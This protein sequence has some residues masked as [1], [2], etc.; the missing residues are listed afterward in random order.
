[1]SERMKLRPVTYRGICDL[2]PLFFKARKDRSLESATGKP[3]IVLMP[4]AK[5]A[6]QSFSSRRCPISS[7]IREIHITTWELH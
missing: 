4:A 1:M 5:R 2:N 6:D 3:N 7:G